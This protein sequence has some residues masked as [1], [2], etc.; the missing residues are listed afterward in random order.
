MVD[1]ISSAILSKVANTLEKNTDANIVFRESPNFN[2]AQALKEAISEDNIYQEIAGDKQAMILAIYYAGT[3][4][5]ST[6]SPRHRINKTQFFKSDREDYGLEKRFVA[7]EWNIQVRVSCS[8]KDIVEAIMLNY[9]YWVKPIAE[10][11][12]TI[13]MEDVVKPIRL[14][15]TTEFQ[16]P[17]LDFAEYGQYGPMYIMSFDVACTGNIFLPQAVYYPK[18]K[19]QITRY[20]VGMNGDVSEF[21]RTEKIVRK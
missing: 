16:E 13:E 8:I 11:N 10:T 17:T 9:M 6:K 15:Y 3:P 19:K 14:T 7:L 21:A 4:R 2:Y 18:I 12:I 1:F 20:F 5:M